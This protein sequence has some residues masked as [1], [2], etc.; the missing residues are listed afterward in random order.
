MSQTDRVFAD[1]PGTPSTIVE[2]GSAIMRRVPVRLLD[3]PLNPMRHNIS[4]QAI[5]ELGADIKFNGL[6]QNLGVV[7]VMGKERVKIE[8]A[9][10]SALERH[11]NAGGRYRVAFGHCRLLAMRA[12]NY[13]ECLCKVFLDLEQTEQGI[14]SSENVHRTDPSDYDLAVMYCEWLKEDGLT[15]SA[16]VKRAGKS[17]EFIYARVELMNGYQDVALALH[18]R[19]IKFSVAR[20]LNRCE[21][22]EYAKMFLNMAI[23]QGATSKLV[24][25]WVSER[26]AHK[27]MAAPAAAPSD[28][29]IHVQAPAV[30]V[31]ECICCGDQ[32]SYN[33]RTVFMCQDDINKIRELRTAAESEAPQAQDSSVQ[34]V[35]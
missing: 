7:P 8:F 17:P 30:K 16:L 3:E 25:A 27:D 24:N 1:M 28:P 29:H 22:P 21:E 15:E 13:A 11:E 33:L 20:A 2:R 6:L 10:E 35:G 12:I 23:D 31:V 5:E 14:M 32:Q 9:T 26:K 19:K 18:E 34:G 4:D